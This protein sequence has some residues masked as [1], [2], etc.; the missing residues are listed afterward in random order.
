[1]TQSERP[2]R[3]RE[4]DR[5]AS[6]QRKPR[7]RPSAAT[8]T[9]PSEHP[10]DHTISPTPTNPR[11]RRHPHQPTTQPT[12]TAQ[13]HAD[14][15]VPDRDSPADPQSPTQ[16]KRELRSYSARLPSAIRDGLLP[17]VSS[18]IARPR[19]SRGTEKATRTRSARL[20][21]PGQPTEVGAGA[22]ASRDVGVA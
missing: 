9:P 6:Q 16:P 2:T 18:S 17:R 8:T 7:P 1:M 19:A 4:P 5:D 15:T 13:E 21:V 14:A 11:K 3:Q 10:A 12:D 22:C 20:A